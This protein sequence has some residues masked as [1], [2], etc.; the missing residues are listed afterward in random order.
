MLGAG[1]AEFLASAVTLVLTAT[2]GIDGVLAEVVIANRGAGHS[3]PTDG[4][5]R[6]LIL[7]VTATDAAGNPLAYLGPEVVSDWAG[8]GS[9]AEA[10]YAGQPGKG[11]ARLLEDWEGEAPSPPWRNGIRGRNGSL[12]LYFRCARGRR[13]GSGVGAAAP[14][15]DFQRVG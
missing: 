3:I 5:M 12:G 10:N 1:D 6:N 9:A 13:P 11:F 7:L 2:Q 8:I 15:T 14:P 4:W